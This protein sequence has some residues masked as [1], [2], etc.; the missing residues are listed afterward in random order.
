[1]VVVVV[2]GVHL[3]PEEF[4]RQQLN[5]VLSDMSVDVVCPIYSSFGCDANFE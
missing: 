2:Q 3:V 5:S 4:I 1:M